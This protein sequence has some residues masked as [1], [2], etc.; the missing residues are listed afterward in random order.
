MMVEYLRVEK[1]Q[2]PEVREVLW[3]EFRRAFRADF[4]QGQHVSIFGPTESGKTTVGIEVLDCRDY[5]LFLATKNEDDLIAGLSKRGYRIS[6]NLEIESRDGRPYPPRIVFWPRPP[7]KNMELAAIS[8]HQAEEM[9]KA[10]TYAYHAGNWCV[11]CDEV[12][13]LHNDLKLTK[14]LNHLWYHG[15]SSGISVVG[16]AQRPVTVPRAMRSS[17]HHIFIF[18]TNDK[19]DLYSLGDISGGT[20]IATV[21]ETVPTL[22]NH[23]FL[24]IGTRTGVLLRSKVDL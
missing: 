4:K 8:R 23:E 6:E 2:E 3:D 24:Y 11:F 21:R 1:E 17:P 19:D 10:I 15:R 9:D 16:C 12:V 7:D 13:W 22:R 20:N 18:Q 14:H 5:V